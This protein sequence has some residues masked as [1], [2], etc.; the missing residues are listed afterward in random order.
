MHHYI[1]SPSS[2]PPSRWGS[3]KECKWP[4]PTAQ[5]PSWWNVDQEDSHTNCPYW[6]LFGDLPAMV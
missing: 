6:H 1:T 2:P 4:Q 5:I 3:R